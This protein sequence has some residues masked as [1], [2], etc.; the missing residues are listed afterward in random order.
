MR[1]AEAAFP[2]DIPFIV[3]VSVRRR[4]DDIR[5]YKTL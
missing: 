5:P 4:A 1:N 2:T 3:V